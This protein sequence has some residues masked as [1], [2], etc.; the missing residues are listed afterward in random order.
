MAQGQS[1][2]I[3]CEPLSL[4]SRAKWTGNVPHM[5]ECLLCKHEAEKY[6]QKQNTFCF[7]KGFPLQINVWSVTIPSHIAV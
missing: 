3:V 2:Q 4:K 7:I 6:H 1:M 5:V